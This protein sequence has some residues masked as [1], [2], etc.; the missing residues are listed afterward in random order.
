MTI[1]E[2]RFALFC[3]VGALN[4]AF[5]YAVFALLAYAGMHHALALLLATVAG[6]LFNFFSTGRLVFGSRETARL[7]RFVAVYVAVYAFNVLAMELLMR[8]G[9]GLYASGALSMCMAAVMAYLLQARFV[10]ARSK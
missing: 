2:R 1:L 5:G 4:T 3:A 10:F 7:P 8:A 9:A 6:I